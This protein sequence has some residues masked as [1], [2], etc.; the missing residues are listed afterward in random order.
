MN[1]KTIALILGVVAAWAVPAEAQTSAPAVT[2]SLTPAFVSQYMFRGQRL[3][4][5]SFEPTVEVD[6]GNL[7]VGVWAN[8]PVDDK[9]PGISDPEIDPYAYYTFKLSDSLSIV[10]GATL[11]TYP[12]AD[13]TQG[14][15]RTTF[16]PN[17][18]LNYTVNGV[19]L[20]PKLYY[21]FVLDGP[22]LEMTAAYALPVKE[23]GTE[24]DFV[25]TWG[26]YEQK[27]I[28]KNFTPKVKAWGDY[29]LAGV[30]APVQ[31]NKD[32][33]LVLGAAYTKGT[34]Q[35]VKQGGTPRSRN[36]LAV[37]RPVFSVSYSYSF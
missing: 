14:F 20:T 18:A 30:S 5:L 26:T 22:T 11:Y 8:F 32:S 25:A 16:E 1:K 17:I 27:D 3:G 13:T 31:I 10:P 6:A 33:K 29:W 24:L 35:W 28:A 12:S 23:I 9:V 36:T 21:D 4:G 2:V 15:Y 19:K 7:G 37:G 34:N